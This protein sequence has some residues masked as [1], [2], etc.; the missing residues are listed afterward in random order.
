M[1]RIRLNPREVTATVTRFARRDTQ[2]VADQ[3]IATAQRLAPVDTGRYRAGFAKRQVT[4]LRGVGWQ[5]YNPV[6]YAPYIEEGTKPHIIRPRKAK[7]LRFKIGGRIVFAQIVHHPGTKAQHILS[8][9][10]RQVGAAA[11]Y[12]VRLS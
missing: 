4:T 3:I 7:A 10:T 8:K 2:K 5:V 11:G 1:A 12:N 6:E 9:A